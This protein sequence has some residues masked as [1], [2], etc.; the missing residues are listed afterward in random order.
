MKHSY[1]SHL[2]CPKCDTRYTI[3]DKHQLCTC[4][5]PLLVAYDMESLAGALNPAMLRDR[6]PSLWRYRELL[7]VLHPEHVVTLGEGLTPLL[8]MPNIGADMQIPGLLMKDE[9]L[10]PTGSFKARGAAVGISKAK[11]LGVTELAMPTNGNAGAAWALYAARAKMKSTV[12]MPIDAPLI[13]RNECAISGSNLYLVNGLISDAGRIVADLVQSYGLYDAS[14]L[15]EPYRIEGKKTMGL[16]IAEQLGWKLPDVIL[17]PTGGGV[18]LI[19]IYKALKELQT[20]GWVQGKLPRLVAVQAE[21][22]APIVKAWDNQEKE[23][24]FWTASKTVAFGI[25]VPKAL[26]D[27]LVLEAV[28]ATGGCAVSI[29]DEELLQEQQRVAE[30]E[31]AFVCPEG[32]ATFAAARKLKQTGWI[33]ENECVIALNTGAGIK[34]P[35]TVNVQVPVLQPGEWITR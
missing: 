17:Y 18:G 5:S 27:F 35:D 20:L 8:P 23:S 34:Y 13:T 29:S 33:G 19:G 30:L 9:G 25:N 21:G 31:G 15:K 32:A 22:C 11:E 2:F 26:G 4:G 10:L 14:T 28:Y 3:E 7:P 16:E 6:E 24:Q 12:I 1:V